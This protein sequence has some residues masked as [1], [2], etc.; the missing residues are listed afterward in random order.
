MKILLFGATGMVGKAV[1]L[2]A[3][4]DPGVDAVVSVVRK[5][6]GIAHAKL[7]EL[8]HKDFADFSGVD[9]SGVDACL[10]CL[11]VS[12]V[13]MSEAD[14]TRVTRDFH[15]AAARR[16]KE[17]SKDAVF[18]VVTGEGTDKDSTTMWARVKGQMEQEIFALFGDRG[19]AFRPGYIH[20]ERGVQPTSPWLRR[21]LPVVSVVVP[22]LRPLLKD[23]MTTSSTLGRAMVRVAKERRAVVAG[24]PLQT[25]SS[26]DINAF[27]A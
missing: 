21:L 15:L 7:T 27:M 24:V 10:F 3:L 26:K 5:P 25:L 16:V 1:L 9:F 6:G 18:A 8:V 17:Q 14:Y 20:P 2:E 12:S 22:L 11:G 13:G 4:D 23:K 19:F